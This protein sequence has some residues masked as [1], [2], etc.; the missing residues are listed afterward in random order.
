[1]PFGPA[2]GTGG[3]QTG[4]IDHIGLV[5]NSDGPCLAGPIEAQYPK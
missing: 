2:F 4:F 3:L 1:M 5:Y